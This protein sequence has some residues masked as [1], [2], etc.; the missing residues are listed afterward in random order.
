MVLQREQVDQGPSCRART[1]LVE[2]ARSRKLAHAQLVPQQAD[3]FAHVGSK[4]VVYNMLDVIS[5]L[6][7]G[8]QLAR[9]Q[10]WFGTPVGPHISRRL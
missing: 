7:K 9:K 3:T 10:A 8:A 1:S 4:T 5:P 2:A 6:A